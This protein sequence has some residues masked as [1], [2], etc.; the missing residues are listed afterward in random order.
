MVFPN[1]L[2]SIWV[3]ILDQEKCHDVYRSVA[4]IGEQEICT[5]NMEEEKGSCEGDSGGPLTIN[6]QLAGVMSWTVDNI[7]NRRFPDVFMNLA[8]PPYRA[9]ITSTIQSIRESRG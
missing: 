3:P 4:Q 5:A 9:W 8:Y 2:H 6:G 1:E 7:P